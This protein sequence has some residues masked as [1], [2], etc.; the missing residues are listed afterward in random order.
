MSLKSRKRR[1]EL[2]QDFAMLASKY[3][4]FC[5]EWR[6]MKQVKGPLA[7]KATPAFQRALT[8]SIL[9]FHFGLQLPLLPDDRLCPPVPNRWFYCEWVLQEVM[10]SLTNPMHFETTYKVTNVGLDVGTGASAIY[11]L[12]LLSQDSKLHM[13]ASEIDTMSIQSAKI[14]CEAN[15][16]QDRVTLIPITDSSN[17]VGG[18]LS[19]ALAKANVTNLDFI[20]TNPPF[21]DERPSERADGRERTP[22]TDTEGLYPGGEVGWVLDVL[23]DSLTTLTNIGWYSTMLSKKASFQTLER[24]LT[25][26]LGPGHVRSTEFNVGSMTRWFLAW[27]Y[28]RVHSK[29][30]AAKANVLDFNVTLG[31]LDDAVQQVAERV[32][33]YFDSI[34][35]WDLICSRFTCEDYTVLTVSERSPPVL[36]SFMVEENEKL[37][38]R[39]IEGL[40]NVSLRATDW[41]PADGHFVV[42]LRIEKGKGNQIVTVVVEGYRHSNR[43]G[44]A[45]DKFLSRLEGEISR[46]NRRWRR[47][48]ASPRT[49]S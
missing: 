12:L 49:E 13:L 16:L 2:T 7:S 3:P 17:L 41:L 31:E 14:N 29:S 38:E 27:T 15:G 39:V 5:Q 40:N 6:A 28:H 26:F 48:L 19:Q 4:D 34:P 1:R 36:E 9:H 44:R 24:I 45:L 33:V 20:V 10:P 30:P 35:G 22:M 18:P 43:G 21:F 32:T 11:P 25:N 47:L 42:D 8:R 46:S 23:R 37:P